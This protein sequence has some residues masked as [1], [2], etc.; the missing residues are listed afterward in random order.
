MLLETVKFSLKNL[1]YCNVIQIITAK[2][3]IADF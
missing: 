1:N 3:R 2:I